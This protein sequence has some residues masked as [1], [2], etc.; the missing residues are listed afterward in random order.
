MD[1]VEYWGELSYLGQL[2]SEKYPHVILQ[3]K[4]SLRCLERGHWDVLKLGFGCCGG[5]RKRKREARASCTV[6]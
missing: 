6:E 4:A 2:H 1:V 3:D 5:F